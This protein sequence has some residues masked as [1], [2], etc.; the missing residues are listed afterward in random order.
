VKGSRQKGGHGIAING[1]T[2]FSGD[3]AQSSGFRDGR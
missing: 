2:G 1:S 3:P